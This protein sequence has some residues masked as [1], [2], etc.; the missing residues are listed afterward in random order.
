MQLQDGLWSGGD[1]G[2]KV[3]VVLRRIWVCWHS[4][5][6]LSSPCV[7]R[8]AGDVAVLMCA[9]MW[10]LGMACMSAAEA[11]VAINVAITAVKIDTANRFMKLSRKK[12]RAPPERIYRPRL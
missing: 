7:P 6:A 4:H 3:Q 12:R 2:K 1:P 11:A 9:F 8:H 10:L 5:R